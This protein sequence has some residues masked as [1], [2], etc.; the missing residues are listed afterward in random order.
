MEKVQRDELSEDE[1]LLA[2]NLLQ[3]ADVEL[4][5]MRSLLAIATRMAV[6]LNHPAYDCVYLALAAENDCQLVT[7]DERLLRK[8]GQSRRRAFRNRATSLAE[9]VG[10]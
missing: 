9:A 3:A 2:A 1:A 10:L 6:E 5:P 4:L 7:A 8:L